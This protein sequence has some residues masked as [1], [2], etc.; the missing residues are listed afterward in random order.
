MRHPTRPRWRSRRARCC[1]RSSCRRPGIA[2]MRSASGTSRA[3]SSPDVPLRT[4]GNAGSTS[5][6]RSA[7][8]NCWKSRRRG[9]AS[10]SG[11]ASA[12]SWRSRWV[13]PTSTTVAPSAPTRCVAARSV[14]MTACGRRSSSATW[15]PGW[16]IIIISPTTRRAPSSCTSPSARCTTRWTRRYGRSAP[17]SEA[18]PRSKRCATA[19]RL[20]V[21]LTS[22]REIA[23]STWAPSGSSTWLA[24][25]S[26]DSCTPLGAQTTPWCSCRPTTAGPDLT[27]RVCPVVGPTGP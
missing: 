16:C 27:S 18:T 21:S 26:C 13:T 25:R 3:P 6:R 7:H 10:T 5:R 19:F 8:A 9:A 17:Q 24:R 1:F 15:H 20:M 12:A 23:S 2:T 4:D 11:L 14:R 22:A